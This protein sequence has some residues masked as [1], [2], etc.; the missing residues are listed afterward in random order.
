MILKFSVI[1]LL[2]VYNYQRG[3]LSEL[4]FQQSSSKINKHFLHTL[5]F[6][7]VCSHF[8]PLKNQIQLLKI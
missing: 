1:R 5:I 6:N 4:N 2:N 8:H 3:Q 7:S